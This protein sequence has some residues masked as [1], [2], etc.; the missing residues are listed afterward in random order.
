MKKLSVLITLPFS[1]VSGLVKSGDSFYLVADDENSLLVL[2]HKNSL[3]PLFPGELPEEH[4]ERKRL[5]PDL[6]SLA[7]LNGHIFAFP[8]GSTPQRQTGVMFD[9]QT[10]VVERFSLG[11][12]YREIEKVVIDLNIEGATFTENELLLFQRGNGPSG[13]NAVI[14]LDQK[15]FLADVARAAITASSLRRIQKIELGE[16]WGFTDACHHNCVIYFLAVIE[17]AKST[18]EDGKFLG[19]ELGKMTVDGRILERKKLQID[20]KPE[21]L[22]VEGNRI[23]LVTDADDRSVMS[24]IYELALDL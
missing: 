8:S 9:P 6:E 20:H 19:A 14:H 2:N 12:L 10:E 1:A 22:W 5:K 15:M 21:G 3:I 18:Y 23:Y 24:K 7:L 11:N 13:I 17:G 16:G 4:D